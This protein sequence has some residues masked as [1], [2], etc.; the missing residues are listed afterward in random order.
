MA[1]KR[2]IQDRLE[3]SELFQVGENLCNAQPCKE[4]EDVGKIHGDKM[5]Y[6]NLG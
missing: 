5:E 4:H 6:I 3:S 2:K 1:A